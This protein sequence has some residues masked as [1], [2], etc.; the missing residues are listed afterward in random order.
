MKNNLLF[1]SCFP[2]GNKSA[3]SSTLG[4]APR[5]ALVVG[6]RKG[7]KVDALG[8]KLY[9][10]KRGRFPIRQI[11]VPPK[12]IKKWVYLNGISKGIN[13][14]TKVL[15]TI[16]QEISSSTRKYQFFIFS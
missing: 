14:I 16:L 12:S 8:K 4:T 5:T 1:A 7:I 9:A 6:C 2:V 11:Y 10:F 13:Q 15:Y 3:L